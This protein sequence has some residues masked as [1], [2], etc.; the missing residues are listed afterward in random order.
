M[1]V[2]SFFTHFFTF[3]A[4]YSSGL[5]VLPIAATF[6]VG[7]GTAGACVSLWM[8][9]MLAFSFQAGRLLDRHHPRSIF[10]AGG[11][12]SAAGLFALS[13]TLTLWQAIVASAFSGACMSL[14]GPCS[15]SVIQPWFNANRGAATGLA[16]MGT[17]AGH[18]TF[19]LVL[20]HLILRIGWRSAL[21]LEAAAL[22]TGVLGASLLFRKPLPG[23]VRSSHENTSEAQVQAPTLSQDAAEAARP[24]DFGEIHRQLHD[25]TGTEAHGKPSNGSVVPPQTVELL[26][27]MRTRAMLGICSFKFCAA[28]GYGV[29]FV[30]IVPMARDIG[31]SKGTAGA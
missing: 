25:G 31:L 7:R 14:C 24:V 17:G 12:C 27:L 26:T 28:F 3:G 21:G 2:G 13:R 6:D 18:L 19:T 29:P 20:E 30:H 23:E 11:L 4:I 1:I 15:A 10:V 5:Y 9:V 8:G 16:M 22:A